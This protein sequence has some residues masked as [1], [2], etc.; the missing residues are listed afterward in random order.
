[1][2]NYSFPVEYEVH[3]TKRGKELRPAADEYR[4]N[5]YGVSLAPIEEDMSVDARWT[6]FIGVIRFTDVTEDGIGDYSEY[7]WVSREKEKK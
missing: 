6:G 3:L 4:D 7:E 5:V 2:S 1:M